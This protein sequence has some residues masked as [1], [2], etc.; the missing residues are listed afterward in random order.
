MSDLRESGSVEQD[1]DVIWMMY[2]PET[3]DPNGT[4]RIAGKDVPNSGLCILDQVKM[5]SGSTGMIALQFDGPLMR[6]RD[7]V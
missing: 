2:R 7:Y 6:L 4:F 3:N 5:R 1:A